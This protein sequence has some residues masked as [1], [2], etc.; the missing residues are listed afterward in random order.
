VP[1]EVTGLTE[2]TTIAAGG[3]FSLALRKD[4]NVM[5]W[6]GNDEGELG[7]GSQT[8]AEVP[9]EVK[10]VQEVTAIAGGEYHSLVL[11]TLSG[12]HPPPLPP[13]ALPDITELS[14]HQGT[15][16]GGTLVTITG[17]GFAG[18]PRVLFGPHEATI[19]SNS[20]ST[21]VAESPPGARKVHVV[22]TNGCE[23]TP[24]RGKRAKRATF[25][26]KRVK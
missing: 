20:E 25:K 7:N 17:R 24:A 5:D 2:V 23:S 8:P 4:G 3:Y 12:P 26:Y 19:K 13:P 6:G 9:I 22:V 10:G 14:P 18:A 15:T 21:I 1:V 11:G 16:L